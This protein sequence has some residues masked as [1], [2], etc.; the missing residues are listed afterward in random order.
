VAKKN[1]LG[2]IDLHELFKDPEGNQM[3]S[4]GIHPNAAGDVQLARIV[5]DALRKK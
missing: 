1:K 4:D 3:L 5:C 2:V